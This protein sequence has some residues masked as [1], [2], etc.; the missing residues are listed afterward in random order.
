MTQI[1]TMEGKGNIVQKQLVDIFN[2]DW[3]SEYIHDL[4]DA[5]QC[6]NR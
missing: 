4:E 5:E 1:G 6:M 3:D 2:R